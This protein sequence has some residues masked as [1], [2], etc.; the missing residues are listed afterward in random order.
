MK[1]KIIA[2]LIASVAGVTGFFMINGDNH[3][4]HEMNDSIVE[5]VANTENT[6]VEKAV[7]ATN[8]LKENTPY[9]DEY[10]FF[11]YEITEVYYDEI[12]GIGL[13]NDGG[14]VLSKEY[15]G[16][17]LEEGDIITVVFEAGVEDNIIDVLKFYALSNGETKLESLYY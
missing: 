14:I 3:K 12:D 9:A 15:D 1:N 16:V 4:M 8:K 6:I 2:L 17:D 13:D 11:T 5:Q 10:D 7:K